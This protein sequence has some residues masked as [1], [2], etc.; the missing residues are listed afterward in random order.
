MDQAEKAREN[1]VR[2][3]AERE[4]FALQRSRRRDPL[5]IDY[6]VYRLWRDG[7]LVLGDAVGCHMDEIEQFLALDWPAKESRGA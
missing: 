7:L 1:K 5:A 2:R 6:G 4:G 3:M